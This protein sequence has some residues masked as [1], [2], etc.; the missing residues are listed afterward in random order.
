MK[1]Y[2]GEDLRMA[3]TNA[4]MTLTLMRSQLRTGRIRGKDFDEKLEF[5]EQLIKE[6]QENFLDSFIQQQQLQGI[7]S[8]LQEINELLATSFELE[9]ILRNILDII[10][11]QTE[12]DRGFILLISED[13][14]FYVP[15]AHNFDRI[16]LSEN[17]LSFSKTIATQ[18]YKTKEP[19][20]VTDAQRD[21]EY[22]DNT[23]T[24][25]FGLRSILAIPLIIAEKVIGAIYL[26]NRVRAGL[27]S[28]TDLEIIK[29]SIQKAAA[30]I[31]AGLK[32]YQVKQQLLHLEA[33]IDLIYKQYGTFSSAFLLDSQKIS[34][35]LLVSLKSLYVSEESA[36]GKIISVITQL[37][38]YSQQLIQLTNMFQELPDL[39]SSP[40]GPELEDIF[41]KPTPQK[42]NAIEGDH[43]L[44]SHSEIQRPPVASSE[45]HQSKVSPFS[46]TSSMHPQPETEG[47]QASRPRPT[48][49]RRP[50]SQVA[51]IPPSS[52]SPFARHHAKSPQE[53]ENEETFARAQEYPRVEG[54][55]RFIPLSSESRV[56]RPS[57]DIRIFITGATKAG[58]TQFIKAVSEIEVDTPFAKS[59]G[60]S[61]ENSE[62]NQKMDFG[63]ISIDE[64]TVLYLFG[65]SGS[66]RFDFLWEIMAQDMA[67]FVVIVDSTRPE[68]FADTREIL[69]RFRA[70]APV[71]YVVAAN[72]QDLSQAWRPDDIRIALRT[73]D[74][75]KVLPCS[76]LDSKSVENILIELL[77]SILEEIDGP[78]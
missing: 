75:T 3:Y 12:A 70:Y 45:Q 37:P 67:G 41:E 65:T 62:S 47:P 6:T 16:K 58:K 66:W 15:V 36:V 32:H 5:L 11:K 9:D 25:V 34:W 72:K 10:I 73:E 46:S 8:N 64:E 69:G 21:F 17:E 40:R 13:N 63:R 7:S 26:D 48:F 39:Q 52:T 24:L 23:S 68:T 29:P 78:R 74:H 28:E 57:Q 33:K 55:K 30:A 38:S 20:I 1:K 44:V 27:F 50:Q 18:V 4:Q 42:P 56:A 77:Y 14:R 43:S 76:V 51:P 54:L 53:K 61:L 2:S 19:I 49:A 71:P 31:E 59:L 35:D 22:K 60:E